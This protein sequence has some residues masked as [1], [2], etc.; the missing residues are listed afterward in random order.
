MNKKNCCQKAIFFDLFETLVSPPSKEDIEEW[1]KNRGANIQGEPS[2]WLKSG[3]SFAL[4]ADELDINLTILRD[5]L[6]VNDFD[7][8]EEMFNFSERIAQTSKKLSKYTKDF[9][10]DF[11]KFIIKNTRLYEG[12]HELLKTLYNR[13]YAV[14]ILSNL[15]SPYKEI[16]SL[17]S[18]L[19]HWIKAEYFSCR[20]GVKK[21]DLKFF[22]TAIVKSGVSPDQTWMVGDNWKSDIMGG[23]QANLNL[24]YVDRQVDPFISYLV[25]YGLTGL[26]QIYDGRVEIK[27]EYRPL[28][29]ERLCVP[30]KVI[31][32]NMLKSIYLDN[33]NYI[34]LHCMQR[35]N[36]A[37]NITETLN[38]FDY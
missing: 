33:N 6:L 5:E 32:E 10:K 27:R 20:M 21:P 8:I 31:E 30:L 4:V 29:E 13:G 3:F 36:Y 37:S 1:L 7:N 14:F 11:I 26:L 19:S 2:K 18:C 34:K 22:Q 28:L 35:I 23:F 24:I 9:T 25:R 38:F 17:H 12:V 16:L 15:I